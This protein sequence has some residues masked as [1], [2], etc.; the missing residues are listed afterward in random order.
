MRELNVKIA[1]HLGW[2]YITHLQLKEMKKSDKKLN[3]AFKP[4]WYS[5]L[6]LNI[7][8]LIKANYVCRNHNELSIFETNLNYLIKALNKATPDYEI[9]KDTKF[10][11]VSYVCIVNGEV[12]I[13][14]SLEEAIYRALG[15][16]L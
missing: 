12:T 7:D 16:L 5:S 9:S 2:V 6:P 10:N 13:G 3:K 15:K 8:K 1:K 4:G 11:T 14:N